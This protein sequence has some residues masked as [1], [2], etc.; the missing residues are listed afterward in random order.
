MKKVL[1][2]LLAFLAIA[3]LKPAEKVVRVFMIGDSTMANKNIYDAPETGWG[4]VFHELFTDVVE[5]QN[6]AR[7]GRSTKSFRDLGHWK[8]VEKQLQPGDFVIIQFGHN[9]QKKSDPARWAPAKTDYRENLKNYIAEV[10]AKGAYPILCT[11]VNRRKFDDEGVFVDQHGDYPGVVRELASELSIPLIDMHHKSLGLLKELGVE[12]SKDLFMHVAPGVYPKFPEGLVD[13]THFTPFGARSMAKLA[14]EALMNIKNPLRHYLKKSEFPQTYNYQLPTINEVAFKKDT[15]DIRKY[16]AVSG[17]K[18]LAHTAINQ[19]IDMASSTGGGVVLVPTGFWL[20]GP[21]KM[22]SNV[23]LH[24]EDGAFIQ[25]SDNREDYPV[26]LTTWE[27]QPAYRCHAPI[28]GV[29]LVNIAITGKGIMDGAGQVWKQVKKS[30]LTDSQWS[31]LVKSGGVV[32]EA[33]TAWYPSE[34]S[35]YGNENREWTNNIVEGKTKE[36]YEAIRDFLRPNMVSL[37]N[38]RNV[39]LEDVT[40]LNSPAWTLHPLLCKHITIRNVNVKNP[41]FGQNND[42][43]DVESCTYGI[44]DGCTFDTGDDAITIK[45]GRD[46]PGR[47]RGVA[48]SH[49]IV[50][51]TTVFHGHGGFVIGSEMSGGVHHLYVN[52]CNFL[53]TDIGLRFKTTRGRGGVVKDI[54]ISD[55]NMNNIPGEAIRFNMYYAYKDP[56]PVEGEEEGLPSMQAE[57]FGEGTPVFKDFVMERIYCKGANTAIMMRGIPESQV[58]N[59]SISDAVIHSDHGIALTEAKD[60]HLKNVAVYSSDQKNLIQVNNV[61]GLEIEDLD[62]TAGKKVLLE[63]NGDRSEG[64]RIKNTDLNGA[65]T[66]AKFLSNAKKRSVK[67]K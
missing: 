1:L 21:I 38:C 10:K 23:N 2:G 58:E 67:W 45:S 50:K 31:R 3:A 49:F 16:G 48:T 37:T 63:V 36:D 64:I 13:N 56:V 12:D 19:A 53:G 9:D 40:F 61:N 42:A 17:G 35:K 52:N 26:V 14:A 57:P 60:I 66:K 41:W 34:I 59:I 54:Y 47:D 20:S 29:D 39:L 46:K 11:P 51:N 30:K 55:I 24:L 28:W 33:G 44:L 8:E 5:I 15:F 7:N 32:D 22:K 4:Q 65:E 6:H 27:G 62:Y 18:S 25:F 43:I